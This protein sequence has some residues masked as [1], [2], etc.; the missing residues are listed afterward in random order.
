MAAAPLALDAA[1]SWTEVAQ[2]K[3]ALHVALVALVTYDAGE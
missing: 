1:L 3:I 2:I